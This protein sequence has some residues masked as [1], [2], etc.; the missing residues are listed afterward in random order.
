VNGILAD[1]N[2]EGHLALLLQLFQEGWRH[3]V[4]EI[5][6]LTP[7]SLADLGL[8]PDAS[9]REAWEACQRE[10]VILLTATAMMTALN[11]SRPPFSNATRLQVSPCSRWPMASVFCEISCMPRRS[12]IGCLSVCLTLT[13]IGERD[14]CTCPNEVGD[15]MKHNIFGNFDHTGSTAD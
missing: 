6:H 13:V 11:R 9:D 2:C 1:A 3:D 8:Q 10:Q 15:C 4:W 7:L 12:P 14:G 5:L